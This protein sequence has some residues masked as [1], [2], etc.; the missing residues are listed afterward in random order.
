MDLMDKHSIQD[1]VVFLFFS[2][3]FYLVGHFWV[4]SRSRYL[5]TEKGGCLVESSP[6]H[7]FSGDDLFSSPSCLLVLYLYYFLVSS[8]C[9]AH[10]LLYN[11]KGLGRRCHEIR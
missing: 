8:F 9:F 11:P 6:F 5:G 3:I 2:V 7:M 4:G 10:V 1:D